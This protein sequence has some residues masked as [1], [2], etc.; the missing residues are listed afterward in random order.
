MWKREK[1]R[2]RERRKEAETKEKTKKG[3]K[4]TTGII[5]KFT[6]DN[7]D[8]IVKF[9][10]TF[11][12][13]KLSKYIKADTL[14]KKL[15]LI[16]K[17]NTTNMHLFNDDCKL[18]KYTTVKEIIDAHAVARLH[19]YNLRKRFLLEVLEKKLKK[20]NN[21]ARYIQAVLDDELD[22]RRKKSQELHDILVA[23]NYDKI[24]DSYK[25]LI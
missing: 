23:A 20:M 12:S 18:H 6:D 21:K 5:E 19:H 3:K 14:D 9:T 22:L 16:K 13:N 24:D 11:P 8:K 25:Y 15:K 17:I 2:E 4:K 1:K 10:L 7:T